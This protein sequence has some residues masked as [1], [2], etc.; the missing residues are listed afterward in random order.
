MFGFKEKDKENWRDGKFLVT[1]KS[2]MEADILES[3]LNAEGIPVMRRSEGFGNA[4]EIIMGQNTA[5]ELS[6]YVP[7]A[8]LVDALNIISPDPLTDEEI[9]AMGKIHEF[10]NQEGVEFT[11][12]EMNEIEGLENPELI[13]EEK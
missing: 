4:A 2:S 7:E 3:K 6:L 8:A 1:V 10:E 9:E 11:E 13:D 12:E 5:F